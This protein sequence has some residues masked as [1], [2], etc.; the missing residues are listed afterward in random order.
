[1]K[2]E[3]THAPFG[4]ARDVLVK[5]DVLGFDN[6]SLQRTVATLKGVLEERDTRIAELEAKL[7]QMQT[8]LDDHAVAIET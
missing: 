1:M 2:T 8:L 7:E 5:N 6:L 4:V 3:A